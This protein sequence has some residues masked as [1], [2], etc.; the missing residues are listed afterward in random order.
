MLLTLKFK[1]L[2][3]PGFWFSPR[4][5]SPTAVHSYKAWCLAFI[6][7]AYTQ[8]TADKWV[9][10]GLQGR[11]RT[12]TLALNL[13]GWREK[14]AEKLPAVLSM[15]A[16]AL[17]AGCRTCLKLFLAGRSITRNDFFYC[18]FGSTEPGWNTLYATLPS[19]H[20][21]SSKCSCKRIK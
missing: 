17:L 19:D 13:R 5:L 15:D 10:I 1:S 16:A 4:C 8:M 11:S 2:G 14:K 21:A 20:S 18:S 6:Y 12:S 7:I 3:Q 9:A